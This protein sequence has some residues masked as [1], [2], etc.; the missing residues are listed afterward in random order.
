MTD[1]TIRSNWEKYGHPDGKQEFSV[2]I[3][4]PKWIV[5]SRNN[6]W[7]LLAYGVVF[8]AG[9]PYLVVRGTQN[10]NRLDKLNRVLSLG[11]LVVRI[12]SKHE[13]WRQGENCR[14]ILQ[15]DHRGIDSD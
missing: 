4:I 7:V 3:A 12:T 10:V 8:G 13:G 5:E 1:E 11:T 6:I 2:G 9:L 15:G 14:N